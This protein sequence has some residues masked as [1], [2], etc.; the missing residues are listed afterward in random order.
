MTEKGLNK[1]AGDLKNTSEN[2]WTVGVRLEMW[3]D[4][5]EELK[6]YC[7]LW[8]KSANNNRKDAGI[9]W[10][11]MPV[12]AIAAEFCVHVGRRCV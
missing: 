6:D 9:F 8:K 11:Q 2:P 7:I 1:K 10:T 5:Y 3:M 12:T 4:F